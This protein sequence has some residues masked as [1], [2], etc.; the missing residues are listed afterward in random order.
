M[1]VKDQT[2]ERGKG[3]KKL[4]NYLWI[5]MFL[6]QIPR[7]RSIEIAMHRYVDPVMDNPAIG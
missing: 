4:C 6:L 3:Y 5:L 1:H 2:Y 7:Y